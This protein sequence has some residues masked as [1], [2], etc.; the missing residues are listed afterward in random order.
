MEWFLKI[1]HPRI[2]PLQY[3]MTRVRIRGDQEI[4]LANLVRPM[5]LKLR[6]KDY[7]IVFVGYLDL[8]LV[9]SL[10]DSLLLKE[11]NI[12]AHG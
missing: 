10:K 6:V 2:Q 5:S 8:F 9:L 1:T 11:T 12:K 7:S 4:A 3:R